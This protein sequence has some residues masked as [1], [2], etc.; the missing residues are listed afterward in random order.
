M[1]TF[2]TKHMFMLLSLFFL[3]STLAVTLFHYDSTGLDNLSDI[4]KHTLFSGLYM[5]ASAFV[6]GLIQEDIN[7]TG[8][9]INSH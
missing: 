1:K 9:K 3:L 6:A 7:Q 2:I 8:K 4:T 5:A